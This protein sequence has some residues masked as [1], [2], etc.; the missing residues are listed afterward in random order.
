MARKKSEPKEYLFVDGYNIINTWDSFKGFKK[1][2]LEEARVK[3][4]DIL[5]EHKAYTGIDIIL[6]FDAHLVKGN[7]GTKEEYKGIKIVY[8]KEYETADHY[9]ERT[10]S[11]MSRLK[12]IRVATSDKLEQ[13]II[14]SRGATRVSARE[15]EIEVFGNKKLVTKK[16]SYNNEKNDYH[17]GKM[18][19]E[20]IEKLKKI[21][22]KK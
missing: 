19:E 11:K 22:T 2:K 21:N 17:F 13:E 8:T 9:I 6:V 16:T 12:K 3:L 20:L 1:E 14:L 7:N 5:V 18:S 15:L 10:I 4:K